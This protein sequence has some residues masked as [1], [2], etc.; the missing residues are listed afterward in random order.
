MV[1]VQVVLVRTRLI[2]DIPFAVDTGAERSLLGYDHADEIGVDYDLYGKPDA[3]IGGIGGDLDVYDDEAR[4]MF[5]TSDSSTL[6]YETTLQVASR[7]G[8]G[9][10]SLLGL[11]VLRGFRMVSDWDTNEVALIPRL[12]WR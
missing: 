10:P 6:T 5:R 2:G 4:L 8:K 7:D 9:I 11:D 12:D 3:S 1:H